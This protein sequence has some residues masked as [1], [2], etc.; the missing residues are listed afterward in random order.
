ML[1]KEL[2]N[3]DE[4]AQLLN[5]TRRTLL[6][7]TREKKIECVRISKKT[8]LFSLEAIDEFVR[9]RT[10]G[11]EFTTKNKGQAGVKSPRPKSKKKGGEKTSGESWRDLR[12]EVSSWES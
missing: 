7:L 2:M 4:A 3:A 9:Q 5:V 6:R 10:H 11:V 12:M 1:G 8:I